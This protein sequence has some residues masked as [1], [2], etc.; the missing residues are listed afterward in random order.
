[1]RVRVGL[2]ACIWM[3]EKFFAFGRQASC[4]VNGQAGAGIKV[5]IPRFEAISLRDP[6]FL[7]RTLNVDSAPPAAS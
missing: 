2:R 4:T 5:E 6:S 1:M 7:I 3:V